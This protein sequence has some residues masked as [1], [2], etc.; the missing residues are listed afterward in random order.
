MAVNSPQEFSG[1][2]EARK[3]LAEILGRPD[4]GRL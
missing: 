2:D 4:R 3:A 1:K